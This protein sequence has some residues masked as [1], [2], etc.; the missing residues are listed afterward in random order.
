M[1]FDDTTVANTAQICKLANFSQQRLAALEREGIVRRVGRGQWPLVA[2]MRALFEHVREQRDSI[3]DTRRQWEQVKVERERLRIDRER[4]E[5]VDRSE[6]TDAWK[7]C[8]GVVVANLA[9]IPSRCSR[10]LQMRQTIERELNAARHEICD[11]FLRQVEALETSG[12][13]APVR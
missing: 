4:H 2:T 13:A 9:N 3:S 8:W 10:D 1:T 5:V 12:E 6:F 7:I 11:E